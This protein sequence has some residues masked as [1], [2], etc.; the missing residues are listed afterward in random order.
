MYA[1]FKVLN[2]SMVQSFFFQ[3][4]AP[5]IERKLSHLEN[6][7]NGTGK[8]L[9]IGGTRLCTEVVGLLV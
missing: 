8:K 6:E 1:T 4:S 3:Y 2:L 7:R 9:N 5:S